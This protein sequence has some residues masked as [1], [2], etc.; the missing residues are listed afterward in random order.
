MGFFLPILGIVGSVFMLKYR[1]KIGD[2][3]GDEEWMKYVG[4]NYNLVII[5]A[6]FIFF[7]CLATLTGTTDILFQ[8]ILWLLPGVNTGGQT[9]ILQ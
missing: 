7:W 2:M 6:F 8:P 5:V 1:E 9:D 4:G 3:I